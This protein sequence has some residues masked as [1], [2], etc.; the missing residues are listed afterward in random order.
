[1]EACHW[2]WCH[3]GDRQGWFGLDWMVADEADRADGSIHK[4]RA[5][6]HDNNLLRLGTMDM[7]L[8]L[9]ILIE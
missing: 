6:V 7:P 1:M 9:A 3:G 4:T 5:G 8:A 2:Q